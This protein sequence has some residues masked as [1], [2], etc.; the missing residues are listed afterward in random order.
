MDINYKRLYPYPVLSE[1]YDDYKGGKYSVEISIEQIF[2][3]IQLNFSSTL[4]SDTLIEMLHS[5]K[6]RFIYHV[7]CAQTGY[8]EIIITKKFKKTKVISA[9]DLRGKVQICPYIV[10]AEDIPNYSNSDFHDD[11]ADITFNIEY[12]CIMGIARQVDFVIENYETSIANTDSIFT[13]VKTSN[14]QG[15]EMQFNIDN[16]KI[17]IEMPVTEYFTYKQLNTQPQ[18]RALL[19][20]LTI[21]PV[22]I[23]LFQELRY[24]PLDEYHQYE[25]YSWYIAIKKALKEKHNF[26]LGADDFGSENIVVLAQELIESPLE[27][28]FSILNEVAN[29]EDEE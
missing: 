3:G 13:I 19:N 24:L 15:K 8:R 5:K 6:I 9:S 29:E 21:T 20:S 18:F 28:A 1:F 7:E 14:D 25:D 4:I 17:I 11:Y 10:A 26:E 2:E 22:L 16:D 27:G 12:G 23:Y